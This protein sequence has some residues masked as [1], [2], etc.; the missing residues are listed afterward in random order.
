MLRAALQW[1]RPPHTYWGI[2]GEEW[3]WEDTL[4]SAAYTELE[5]MRCS[6]GCGGWIDEC[7]D[8]A[9]Q[10]DWLAEVGY[11]YRRAVLDQAREERATELKEPGAYLYLRDLRDEE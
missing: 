8:P 3:T 2:P 1:G 7:T 11:N 5:R 9:L 6:C 10:D 4:L